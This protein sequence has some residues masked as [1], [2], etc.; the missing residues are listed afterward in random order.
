[1]TD[2]MLVRK[3]SRGNV[4]LTVPKDAISKLNRSQEVKQ[5]GECIN[6]NKNP[7]GSRQVH[8]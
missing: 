2:A 6:S 4:L 3:N 7:S 8:F 1:M 5:T